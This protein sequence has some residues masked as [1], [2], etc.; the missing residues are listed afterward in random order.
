MT[1]DTGYDYTHNRAPPY[2]TWIVEWTLHLAGLPDTVRIPPEAA[3]V[4]TPFHTDE[5][6]ALLMEHLNKPL[7]NCSI[8]SITQGFRI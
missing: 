6:Q 7:L 1:I 5:W 2:K 8:S 4:T 3:A